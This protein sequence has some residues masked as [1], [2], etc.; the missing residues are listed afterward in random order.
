MKPQRLSF[1]TD[2]CQQHLCIFRNDKAPQQRRLMLLHGA[3]V[4]GELTWTF[5][6]HYLTQWS[7]IYVPDLAGMGQA[8][9]LNNSQPQLQDYAQQLDELCEYLKLSAHDFDYAGYSFGGMLLEHWLRNQNYAGLV[10]LIEPAM[11]F[12]GYCSQVLDK[13]QNYSKVAQAIF[14]GTD[15]HQTYKL[16]LDSVSPNRADDSKADELTI[17]R[18]QDNPQGFAQA[19][20]AITQKLEDDCHYYTD[21]QAPWVGASFVGGLSWPVMHQRHQYLAQH[22]QS[23]HYEVVPNADHSLVFTR[24]RSIARVMNTVAERHYDL[25]NN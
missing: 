25:S 21:W 20:A 13:A 19:L 15:N 5:V 4:G 3:G 6:A 16:F 14:A 12:S 23:W 8:G 18:L 10:F 11:L 1:T 9:F 2:T 7:E 17:Q 22:S 24:P